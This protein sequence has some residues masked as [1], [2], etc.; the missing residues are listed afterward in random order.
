MDFIITR[1]SIYD[2]DDKPVEEAFK[3]S[4]EY[5]HTRTCT[6]EEFNRKF[7][8][9]E[10]LWKSKGKNHKITEKGYI[11][12]QEENKEMWFI[13]LK[14]FEQLKNFIEK[15]GNI[16]IGKKNINDKDFVIEIY[17][18]YRE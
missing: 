4:V 9:R 1:T 18:D 15:Y 10:G 8:E 16:I 11:T 17:D 5:W 6:E 3:K 14:N 7:S 2:A 13:S 12:R